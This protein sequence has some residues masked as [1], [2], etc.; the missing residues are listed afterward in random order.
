MKMRIYFEAVQ[1]MD[2]IV[3]VNKTDLPQEIDMERVTELA[4]GNRSYY[5]IF[6]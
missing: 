4:V 2:V 1:G 6:N 3:I 5:N